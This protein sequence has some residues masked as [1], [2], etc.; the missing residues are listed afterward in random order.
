MCV[1]HL[2]LVNPRNLIVCV[3]C[4]QQLKMLNPPPYKQLQLNA[5]AHVLSQQ[6]LWE[7]SVHEQRLRPPETASHGQEKAMTSGDCCLEHEQTMSSPCS[8]P[9]DDAR[10]EGVRRRTRDADP[11]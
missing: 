7:Q 9:A 8:V 3:K 2:P 6:C 10:D 1:T 11:L 5:Q 4:L